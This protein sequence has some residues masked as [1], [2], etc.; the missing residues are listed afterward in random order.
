MYAAEWKWLPCVRKIRGIIIT[1]R[2]MIGLNEN[3]YE[4]SATEINRNCFDFELNG[5]LIDFKRQME[6]DWRLKTYQK[7]LFENFLSYYPI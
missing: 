2:V 1:D 5:P 4:I 6:L 7:P 3:S